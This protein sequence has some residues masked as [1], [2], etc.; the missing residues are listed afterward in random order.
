ME[1][2]SVA[3]ALCH[4]AEVLLLSSLGIGLLAVLGFTVWLLGG[5]GKES[6][7]VGLMV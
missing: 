3:I 4:H 5:F 6:K 1:A 2:L 7:Q